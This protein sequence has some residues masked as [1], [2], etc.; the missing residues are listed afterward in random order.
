[1]NG[2]RSKK[3]AQQTWITTI[4]CIQNE[5]KW[6]KLVNTITECAFFLNE[7]AQLDTVQP[8]IN[9]LRNLLFFKQEMKENSP[10]LSLSLLCS[11]L[12][13][14]YDRSIAIFYACLAI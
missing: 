14:S 4:T 6:K 12:L 7:L 1:M 3:I 13:Y 8:R 11:N 10:T 2:S 5:L 9:Y